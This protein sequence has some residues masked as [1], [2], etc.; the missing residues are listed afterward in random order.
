MKIRFVWIIIGILIF[1]VIV[2][3][4]RNS[5]RFVRLTSPI[6]A[7]IENSGRS[8]RRIV[9]IFRDIRTLPAENDS[10]NNRLSDLLS[11]NARLNEIDH[12]NQL[13]KDELKISSDQ[14]ERHIVAARIVARSPFSF[15]EVVTVDRGS[16]DGLADGQA[17]TL[18][19]N[20]VGKVV[21]TSE[22]SAQLQL[23][24]S[25]DAIIQARLQNSRSNG[26]VRG[27]V[28]GLQLALIAQ[29][30]V[31]SPGENVIT[32]GLG[33]TL[34]PGILIGTVLSVSSKKSDVFQTVAV[35]PATDMN[36]VDIVFIEVK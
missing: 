11:E 2:N 27:G 25:S 30:V 8:T 13:L 5:G 31:I 1:A 29:D 36:T 35:K 19:G 12:E 32:S 23:I 26:I 22:R 9:R 28:Q 10:L 15:F 24:T 14:I 4:E 34:R 16:K 33:G 3:H 21:A 18:H 20:L 7:V 6:L 17:A